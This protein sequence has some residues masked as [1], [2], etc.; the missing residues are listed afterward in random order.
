MAERTLPI[1]IGVDLGATN[2]NVALVDHSGELVGESMHVLTPEPSEPAA[3]FDVIAQAARDVC[4][5]AGTSCDDVDAIGIATPGA[6]DVARDVVTFAPNLGWRDVVPRE[7][8]AERLPF[9]VVAVE[10]DVNAALYAEASMGAVRDYSDAIAVWIGT[11]IGGALL[12]NG[13]IDVGGFGS[14]GEIGQ[15]H[16]PGVALDADDP[17]A[18]WIERHAARP[19][20]DA[21]IREGSDREQGP[22]SAA[23]IAQLCAEGDQVAVDAVARATEALV[24]V[25]ASVCT[26]LS[27]PKVVVGGGLAE[28]MPHEWIVR[29]GSDVRRFTH[30]PV[31]AERVDVVRTE[32]GSRAGLTGA[33]LLALEYTS[34][35]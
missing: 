25:I 30:P 5:A 32:L 11:G 18:G 7:L 26:L 20:I 22:L 16:T 1:A 27:V 4:E 35:R 29:L 8:V 19:A 15:L 28:H 33:A 12:R 6:L 9:K 17:E 2:M 3:V 13:R 14:A 31:L 24:P 34:T 21:M 10:N 23:G